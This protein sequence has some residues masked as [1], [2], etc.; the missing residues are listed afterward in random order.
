[1]RLIRLIRIIKLYNYAVKSNS[2][3][4][5]AKQR[6]Q[7]KLSANPMIAA[8]KKELEPSRLGKHLSDHLTRLL[9]IGILLLLMV[10]PLLSYQG[11]NYSTLSGLREV[12]WVG[13][14]SCEKIDGIETLCNDA[15]W[16][17]EEG[18]HEKLRHF[19]LS[20]RTSEGEELQKDLLW[21]YVPDFTKGGVLVSIPSVPDRL[22]PTKNMWEQHEGCSGPMVSNQ[23]CNFRVKEM[24]LVSY[25]PI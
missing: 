20:Q 11:N 12:F 24:E 2:E 5:E 8:L 6:E 23:P 10:L 16:I 19:I 25:Q 3:A 18:W 22:D 14:S 15:T 13:S 4:E 9:I 7:D 1:V 17:T 21:L